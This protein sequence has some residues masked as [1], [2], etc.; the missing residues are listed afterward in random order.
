MEQISYAEIVSTLALVTA[1]GALAW[2]IFRDIISEKVIVDFSVT[3]GEPGKIKNSSVS[4]FAEAGSL[5]P[6]HYFDTPGTLIQIVNTGHKPVCISGV[7]G[8]LNDGVWISMAVAGLPKMLQPYEVFSTI[9]DVKED[10]L[11]M[12]ATGK[13]IDLWAV[14]TKQKKWRI[15]R[16]GLIRLRE[17]ADYIISKRHI[18]PPNQ[19]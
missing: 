1:T 13:L 4:L 12:V 8:R 5:K 16:E 11:D 18:A 14:D 15:S 19:Y 17:T 9:S 6:N 3:F 10:F 7:G 2:N